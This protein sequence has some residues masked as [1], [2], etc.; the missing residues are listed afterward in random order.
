MICVLCGWVLTRVG[1]AESKE[2]G[3]LKLPD[4]WL[5]DMIDEYFYQVCFECCVVAV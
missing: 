5:W 3:Q 1:L 4:K 2:L